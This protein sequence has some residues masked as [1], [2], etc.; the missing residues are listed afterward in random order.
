MFGG[1]VFPFFAAL[2]Y[3]Y[4]KFTGRM[5]N[6]TLGKIHF[7][8]ML[9]GFYVQS[10]GQMQVGLLGMRRRIADYDATLG[11][12]VTQ[13]AVTIAAYVIGFAVLVAVINLFVSARSGKKAEANPW[14]SRSPEFQLPSPLPVVNYE[15][16]FTVIG[17]PY[18]YGLEGSAYVSI[19]RSRSNVESGMSGAAPAHLA[20]D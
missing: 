13:L 20:G 9:L 5:Y 15:R 1:F 14:R 2:Y 19:D 18:D 4:P 8:M 16:P 10:L 17:E 7:W 11:L 12:D 3:W 6:E